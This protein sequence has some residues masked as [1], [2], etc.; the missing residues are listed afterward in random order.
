M[1]N[2]NEVMYALYVNEEDFH[3]PLFTSTEDAACHI[4]NNKTIIIPIKHKKKT[5]MSLQMIYKVN[6]KVMEF[7]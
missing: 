2:G 4:M 7:K 6:M 1:V 5:Y 3:G